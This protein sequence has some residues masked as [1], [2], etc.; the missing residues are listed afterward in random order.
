MC[1]YMYVYIYIYIRNMC[2][3]IYIYNS[4]SGL[5]ILSFATS[6]MFMQISLQPPWDPAQLVKFLRPEM[7]NRRLN[8]VDDNARAAAQTAK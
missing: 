7:C 1:V 6:L 8:Q 2:I 5:R 4:S 3:D